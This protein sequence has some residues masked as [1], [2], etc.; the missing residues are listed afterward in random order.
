[1]IPVGVQLPEGLEN[2]LSALS[3][4]EAALIESEKNG[5]KIRAIMICNPHN[6]LGFCYSKE[7]L[8]EYL[9]FAQR[10]NIHLI[11]D[12]IY[13]LSVFK[14]GEYFSLVEERFS[15]RWKRN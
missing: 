2:S 13:A 15:W 8:I 3:A 10:W 12:E 14:S 9:K 6:P 4:Y 5:V 1:M 7:V 11:S